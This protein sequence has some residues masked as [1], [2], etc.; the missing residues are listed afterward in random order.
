MLEESFDEAW[1]RTAPELRQP[2]AYRSP[3]LWW[4]EDR[5]WCVGTDVDLNSSYIGASV[6]CIE[7]LL[8]NPRL[9]ILPVTADQKVSFDADAINPAPEGSIYD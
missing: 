8:S 9:E 1:Y 5:A 3:S 7:A 6:N 2:H 4:P